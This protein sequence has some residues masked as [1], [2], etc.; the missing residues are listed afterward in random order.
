MN[1]YWPEF[2][3]PGT[4]ISDVLRHEGGLPKL[5]SPVHCDDVST[6]SIK[7]NKVGKLI[8][9]T[10]QFWPEEYKRE[11]HTLTKDWITN[12]IFRR[13]E[14][15]G[16][17]M[18][19]YLR[20]EVRPLIETPGPVSGATDAEMQKYI[21]PKMYDGPKHNFTSFPDDKAAEFFQ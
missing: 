18:A 13:L 19:E 21:E 6:E 1:T 3:K 2:N 10:K 17:T 12:E 9:E 8:E 5:H 4:T 7:Q 15:Q 14:P 20:A 16:R 11:Y